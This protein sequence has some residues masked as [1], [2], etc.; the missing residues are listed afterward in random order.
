MGKSFPS[1]K[2]AFKQK[3]TK[4]REQHLDWVESFLSINNSPLRSTMQ[5]KERAIRSYVGK[6]RREDYMQI[7]NPGGLKSIEQTIGDNIQHYPI[8]VPYL[9][10]LIGEEFDRRFEWRAIITNPNSIS[11]IEDDKKN[12]L[13]EKI[14]QLIQDTSTSEDDMMKQMEKYMRYLYVEYQDAREIR[15]NQLLKHFIKELDLKLKFNQGFKN[16]LTVAEETYIGDVINGRPSIEVADPRKIFVLRAGSSNRFEDA[17]VIVIYDHMAPGQILD[18]Y[19][20]YLSDKD[21]KWLDS[22][23]DESTSD[24]NGDSDQDRD[25]RYINM[26]RNDQFNDTLTATEL[27]NPALAERLSEDVVDAFGNIRVIRMF[28]KSKKLIKRVKSYDDDGQVKY[29]Y[30]SESYKPNLRNGEEVE[31]YWVSHWWEGVKVGKDIYPYIRP[32]E[33]QFNRINDPGYNHPG[34]VGQI[35][36]M[37]GMRATSM[38]NRAM[39]YQLLY[40]ATHHNLN[41]ATSKF[42]G[43]LPVLDLAEIPDGWDVKKW[44]YFA[45]KVGVA[46]KDSF[47]EGTKGRS[48]GMLAGGLSG[49]Q[50]IMNQSGLAE[51]IQQQMNLLTFIEQQMGR[52][53][54]VPPQRLGDIQNRETVGGV[55]RAVTQSSFI[56]NELFK[57]HD[58]VKKRVLTMLLELCKVAYKDNPT[59]IQNVSDTFIN[60]TFSI[61]EEFI[62][63]E[64]GIMVDNET[65]L[66]KLEQQLDTLTHA[67]MQ[68][69]MLKFSDV[70][71]LYVTSSL[72]EKQRTIEASEMEMQKRAD[73]AQ[74]QA[75]QVE[76]EKVQVEQEALAIEQDYKERELLLKE[77]EIMDKN[78]MERYKVDEQELTKRLGL[79][80]NVDSLL[81]QSEDTKKALDNEIKRNEREMELRYKEY[82]EAVRN[83]KA[84]EKLEDQKIKTQK[85][86]EV[87]NKS[88]S[89]K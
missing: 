33:I 28:W 88:K 51:Y 84:K 64:F 21:V 70:M 83:N 38:M 23:G 34:I 57:M 18:R 36:N 6:L 48:V 62:E 76:Q 54:G 85:I 22:T 27:G 77:R 59:K 75:Q 31:D 66:S 30:Y 79:N 89:T 55:E 78:A 50:N 56:T 40:D 49:S 16:V 44:L 19:Y 11:R 87:A 39:P 4:W 47:K 42:F 2:K 81:L 13:H 15:C 58:N 35:Y 37:N 71:K 9:N 68:N 65:D 1:Q 17:D 41:E 5:E 32:R 12:L 45:K 86:K 24:Y 80:N 63:E 60:E 67:A 73:E 8:A 25:E 3:T 61:D 29:D 7:L 82:L 10:V 53:I 69:Q 46:V 14:Q 52:M 43:S 72:A 74:Q 20:R 26:I